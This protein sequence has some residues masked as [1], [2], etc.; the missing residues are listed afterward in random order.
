M[1]P[2]ISI[3]LHFLA[4]SSAL[5]GGVYFNSPDVQGTSSNK[6]DLVF[7]IWWTDVKILQQAAYNGHPFSFFSGVDCVDLWPLCLTLGLWTGGL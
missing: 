6:L 3:A 5:H 2:C 7:G 1:E 4:R